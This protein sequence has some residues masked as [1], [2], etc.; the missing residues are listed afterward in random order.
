MAL[1]ERNQTLDSFRGIA[2]LLVVLGHTIT[3]CT[4]NSQDSFLFNTIWTLQMPLF[5][6]ISGYVT[7]YLKPIRN[8]KDL[9]Q[10]IGRRT[11]SYIV[12]WISWTFFVRGLIFGQTRFLNIELIIYNLDSGYWFLISI[13]IISIIFGFTNYFSSKLTAKYNFSK[14]KNLACILAFA[15][16]GELFLAIIGLAFGLSFFAIKL[17]LYYLPL[18]MLGFLFGRA[19]SYFDTLRNKNIIYD[20]VVSICLVIYLTLLTKINFYYIADNSLGILIRLTA[21]VSGCVVMFG[22]LNITLNKRRAYISFLN[23]VGTHSL[24]VYVIHY[25]VLNIVQMSEIPSFNTFEGMALVMIN[26]VLTI[27][28]SMGITLLLNNNCICKMLLF[29]KKNS[30]SYKLK[31][32]E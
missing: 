9:M 7:N 15:G 1:K 2:M 20:T 16:I 13:W 26:F 6:M 31:G 24:E 30:T 27:I 3:G 29:G 22:L 8:A 5:F 10:Y 17:S 19:K 21:S 11:F 28:I 12:P 14:V 32:T 4:V 18:Y 25:L 23:Y